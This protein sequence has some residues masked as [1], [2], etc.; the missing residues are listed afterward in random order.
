M[1]QNELKQFIA[2]LQ[3]HKFEMLFLLCIGTGLRIGELLALKLPELDVDACTINVIANMFECNIFDADG[4]KHFETTRSSTKNRL[5]RTVPIPAN[6]I[7]KLKA[8]LL[9][10]KNTNLKLEVLSL[11]KIMFF[12]T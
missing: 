4:N 9:D 3:G 7:P 1:P 6:L 2:A 5:C 11:K 12:L 10:H 8:Y